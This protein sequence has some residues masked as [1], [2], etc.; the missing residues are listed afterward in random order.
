[1]FEEELGT[2]SGHFSPVNT[3]E[4]SPDGRAYASG[5]E[6]GNVRLVKFDNNYWE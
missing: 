4:F 1:M 3:L 5:A 2:I 6:E